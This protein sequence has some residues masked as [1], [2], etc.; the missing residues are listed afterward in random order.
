[1]AKKN[2]VLDTNVILHDFKCIE[3]FQ[4]NDVFIPIT[5]LEEVDKF[6]KG[7]EQINFNARAFT[8]ILDDKIAEAEGGHSKKGIKINENGVQI[9]ADGGKVFIL[10]NGL[11]NEKVEGVFRQN[12][13]DH[14]I[15]SAALTL[16]ESS[17]L[18]TILVSKDVNL[19]IKAISLGLKAEDYTTDQVDVEDIFAQNY[20]EVQVGDPG[21]IDSLYISKGEGVD[22]NELSLPFTPL[23]N[24]TF[25]IKSPQSTALVRIDNEAAK[26]R[27]IEKKTFMGITPRNAEQTMAFDLLSDQSLTLIGLTGTAGTGKTLLA[28]AAALAMAEDY[29][30]ILLARP[31]V[32]LANKDIGFLP[33]DY[34]QKILP[35]M[36]PLFDNLNVIKNQFNEGSP[37]ARKL[38]DMLSSEKL[39]IE[40]L[41]YIRGRSL[42]N[43][44]CIIDEAQNLT[45][46]EIKTVITR[47]GDNTRMIFTGDVHQIDSPYL[48]TRSNGLAYMIERM[49]GEDFFGHVNLIQGERSHL[50][51]VA[52]RKL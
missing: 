49:R 32:S 20:S 46:Q 30:Q 14:R 6:K 28:L 15:L 37:Q 3:N 25:V 1:M 24:Q 40:A 10:T 21:I 50:S 52:S 27:S 31:I 41:A 29:Q 11:H 19:R 35:Y 44:I 16:S 13:N 45:P 38:E 51:D 17:T 36:Q 39:V 2:Y 7:Y 33:G 12:L 48:D 5:V 42:S 43:V 47:A 8:R 4:D 23:P 26:A 18:P 34:K 22:I 9:N